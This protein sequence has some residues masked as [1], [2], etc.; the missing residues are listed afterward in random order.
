MGLTERLH[1]REMVFT[2]SVDQDE[3]RGCSRGGHS[4]LVSEKPAR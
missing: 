1:P 3:V 4:V 2:I